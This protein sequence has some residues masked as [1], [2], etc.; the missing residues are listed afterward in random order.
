MYLFIYLKIKEK[1]TLKNIDIF[2]KCQ[3][4][5]SN[6]SK[7]N[8]NNNDQW[9]HGVQLSNHKHTHGRQLMKF[10]RLL[11][12]THPLCLGLTII[13]NDFVDPT[14]QQIGEIKNTH[15]LN[16]YIYRFKAYLPYPILPWFLAHIFTWVQI[17]VAYI[18]GYG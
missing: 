2:Y 12:I 1:S 6:I 18:Q 14:F 17:Y 4:Q 7:N 13:L 5:K 10:V 11:W 8:N 3:M 15:K 9:T 16:I